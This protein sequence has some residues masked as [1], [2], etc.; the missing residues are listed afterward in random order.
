ME[1]VVWEELRFARVPGSGLGKAGNSLFF[2][3]P[4]SAQFS[5]G[6]SRLG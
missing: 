4:G 3:F 6:E 2:H 1:Q 5:I